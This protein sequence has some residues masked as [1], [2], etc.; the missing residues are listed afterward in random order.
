MPMLMPMA[1]EDW[2]E[3]EMETMRMRMRMRMMRRVTTREG[4]PA[5]SSLGG[6]GEIEVSSSSAQWTVRGCRRGWA[7]GGRWVGVGWV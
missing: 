3:M 6:C 4:G 7:L 5:F 2:M 1:M